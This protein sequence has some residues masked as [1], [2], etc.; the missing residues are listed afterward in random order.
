MS[1]ATEVDYTSFVDKRVVVT[2]NL[3]EPNAKGEKAI[4]VEGT[5]GAWN[6]NMGLAIKPKGKVSLEIIPA[7]AIEDVRLADDSNRA[8]KRSTLRTVKLGAARKHLLERH[9]Y[10]LADVN[11]MSEQQAFDFHATLNHEEL[12]LGHV[13]KDKAKDSDDD[14]SE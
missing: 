11:G 4:E 9:G 6:P 1:V 3:D 10:K 8:L 14:K 7:A 13:H 2:Q 5:V 12:D